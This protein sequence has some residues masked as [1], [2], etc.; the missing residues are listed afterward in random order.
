MTPRDADRL[1]AAL[2]LGNEYDRFLAALPVG[3]ASEPLP[4]LGQLRRDLQH[5]A[6]DVADRSEVDRVMVSSLADPAVEWLW[7]RC[8]AALMADRGVRTEEL[9]WPVLPATLGPIGR[10]FY[11]LV[12]ASCVAQLRALHRRQ[13]IP[14]DISAAT[15]SDVGQKLALHRR[16]HGTGGLDWQEWVCFIFRG[17]AF[18]LGRLQFNL[19]AVGSTG[20][21]LLG[22]HVPETGRLAPEACDESLEYA[23]QFFSRHLGLRC[24]VAT[25]RSWLMDEQLA[26]YLPPSSNILRFQRRFTLLPERSCGDA[27]ILEGVFRRHAPR[28]DRLPRRTTLER[29]VVDHLVAGRHWELRAGWLAM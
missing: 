7:R 15:L 3:D 19:S 18:T 27:A 21:A 6:L 20:E 2:G 1:R 4:S 17:E 24:E 8:R 16:M 25:C 26:E 29:A 11:L 13:G 12:F 9:A 14:E 28:L 22:V 10:Y 5:L 23:P